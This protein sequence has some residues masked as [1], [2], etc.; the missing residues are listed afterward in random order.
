MEQFGNIKIISGKFDSKFP[1]CRAVFIDDKIKAVIDPGSGREILLDIIRKN[2][3]N[4]LFNTHY[5]YDHIHY[6]YLFYRS[7]IFLNKIEAECFIDPS[8]ILKRVGIYQVHGQRAI[9]DW[10]HY[11]RQINAKKTPF[12]PSR[13]HAWYLS[14]C[15]LD[16]TY[17]YDETWQCGDTE[18]KFIHTP[19]HSSG[20]CC[21]LFPGEELICTGDIDLTPFGPWYG[22]TDSD[23]DEFT[24]SSRKVADL[25]LKYYATGHE[26]GTFSHADFETQLE[27]YLKKID[28]RDTKILSA[29]ESGSMTI[30][31]LT[32]LGMIY[33][34]PKYI[35][36]PW[37]YAWEQVTL[38]KHLE[39]LKKNK[40]VK[41][42]DNLYE[43][44]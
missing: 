43:T 20:F 40:R 2:R 1:Y 23:I 21:V 26:M 12:S 24:A 35:T 18:F 28:K 6:N 27:K 14:T 22:G 8:N 13:N 38:L 33:G 44:R 10:L 30:E 19:G 42:V 17:A 32:K 3:I 7:K 36:D 5:H 15:R 34:G 37:V 4:Y 31:A 16:G 11:T 9:D 41:K 29:L 39:R 25:E